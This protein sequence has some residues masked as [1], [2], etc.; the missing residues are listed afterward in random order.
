MNKRSVN[1]IISGASILALIA[2][3]YIGLNSFSSSEP[4]KGTKVK[5]AAETKL[6]PMWYKLKAGVD[7]SDI[8]EVLDPA[9][10]DSAQTNE[11]CGDGEVFC[12]VLAEPNGARPNLDDNT[13]AH[14]AIVDFFA[15]SQ[16]LLISAEN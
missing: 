3:G 1:K 2:V 13:D 15:G 4:E 6:A 5:I 7:A 14:D 16:G 12:G 8:D 10:Y 9:N 11:P